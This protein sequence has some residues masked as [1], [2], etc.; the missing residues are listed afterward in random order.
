[1]IIPRFNLQLAYILLF[2]TC[3]ALIVIFYENKLTQLEEKIIELG[4]IV[5]FIGEYNLKLELQK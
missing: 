1:M 4:K 5:V 2:L 3:F